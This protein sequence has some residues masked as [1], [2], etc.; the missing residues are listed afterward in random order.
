MVSD[1]TYIPTGEDWLYLSGVMDALQD[2]INHTNNVEGC[3][4]HSNRGS[5]YCSKAYQ[6]M[7]SQNHL[8]SSMSRKGNCW[9]NA[10]YGKLLGYIEA[11]MVKRPALPYTRR[12]QDR[13]F[14]VYLDFL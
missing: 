13:D 3:I 1:I 10:S 4:L 8:V 9:D 14:R 11:G 12:S 6:Q 5:Q 7:V 2:A